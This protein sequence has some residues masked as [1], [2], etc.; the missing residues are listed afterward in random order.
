MY[1]IVRHS[2]DVI[3]GSAVRPMDEVEASKRGY[4][5]FEVDD[6]DFDV[7]MIGSRLESFS[8]V[9]NGNL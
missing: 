4:K 6:S 5:V 3:V 1:I 7:G 8:E 9:N 2:D